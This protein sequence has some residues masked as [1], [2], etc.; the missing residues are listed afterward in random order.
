MNHS[1]FKD[2]KSVSFYAVHGWIPP[3]SWCLLVLRATNDTEE[4]VWP[5]PPELQGM[6]TMGQ[7]LWGGAC[8]PLFVTQDVSALL[9]HSE[10]EP[11][12]GFPSHPQNQVKNEKGREEQK[13]EQ[14]IK[15]WRTC[16]GLPDS[17]LQ[18]APFKPH[19]R[20]SDPP[21]MKAR[22]ECRWAGDSIFEIIFSSPTVFWLTFRMSPPLSSLP[23][24]LIWWNCH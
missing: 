22:G 19:R 13:W 3:R 21:S 18:Q 7:L 23:L 20:L 16:S 11:W 8:D 24:L 4:A 12:A 15:S 10:K 6:Q 17:C 5:V 1:Q 2:F 9:G 14:H